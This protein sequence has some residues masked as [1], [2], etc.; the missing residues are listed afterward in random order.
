MT[1]SGYAETNN[2][3]VMNCGFENKCH[4]VAVIYLKDLLGI[5]L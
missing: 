4:E 3:L 1:S 2:R 5:Y